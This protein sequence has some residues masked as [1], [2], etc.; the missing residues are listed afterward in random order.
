MGISL[1]VFRKDVPPKAVITNK[2]KTSTNTAGNFNIALLETDIIGRAK[3]KK[4]EH[5]HDL[6]NK[7]DPDS[8]VI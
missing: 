2:R 5:A 6:S 8:V 4:N 1:L 7:S 3:K